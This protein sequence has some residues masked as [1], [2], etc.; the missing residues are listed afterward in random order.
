MKM[1]QKIYGY[2]SW[3]LL[4]QIGNIYIKEVL[5]DELIVDK[6]LYLT[7]HNSFIIRTFSDLEHKEYLN[8]LY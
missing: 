4:K 2:L 8:V 1:G 6:L 5:L 7:K 3:L